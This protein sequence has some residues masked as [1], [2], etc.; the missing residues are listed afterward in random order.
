VSTIQERLKSFRPV[1]VEHALEA[2]RRDHPIVG[3][4]MPAPGTGLLAV[5]R[6]RLLNTTEAGLNQLAFDFEPIERR[7]CLQLL[8]MTE[9][10]L[11]HER[12]VEVIRFRPRSDLLQPAWSLLMN[13][14]PVEKLEALVAQLGATHNWKGLAPRP[15]DVGR[16]EAW[17]GKEKL[18]SGM[19]AD[20]IRTDSTDLD[21]WL[22]G[23]EVDPASNLASQ[24]WIDILR[25]ATRKLI[26]KLGPITLMKR[27]MQE[28]STVQR[29]FQR[30]YLEELEDRSGWNEKVLEWVKGQHGVPRRGNDQTE[31][32]RPVS[33]P[34]RTRFRRWANEAV[35]RAYFGKIDDPHGRF[36]FWKQYSDHVEEATVELD[37]QV[38]LIDFGY[39]GVV[40]F[41]RTGNAAY[42]YP[43]SVFRNLRS[44]WASVEGDFKDRGKTVKIPSGGPNGD[45]RMIHLGGWQ[46][47]YRSWIWE[48]IKSRHVS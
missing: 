9:E 21:E 37:G 17:F 28:T 27:A 10:P 30:K 23:N 5:V 38:G 15:R 22:D 4:A 6:Q 32:W 43:S 18:L 12:A 1:A 44:V 29:T 7:A 39:F 33:D 16:F 2:V 40:E 47:R 34:V 48:L 8:C 13:N 19:I 36:V 3:T 11:V 46:S 35:L 41:S 45:G 26:E 31:F 24:L 20:F 42:V 25:R 14:Y